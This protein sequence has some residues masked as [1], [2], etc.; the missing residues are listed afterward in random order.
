MIRVVTFNFGGN[1]FP[2]FID[3]TD[4]GYTGKDVLTKPGIYE[5][6]T[7]E[8]FTLP[9]AEM[10]G[11]IDGYATKLMGLIA[12]QDPSD[13]APREI[14][15][16]T[17]KVKQ[18]LAVPETAAKM[19][20]ERESPEMRE[21]LSGA[22]ETIHYYEAVTTETKVFLPESAFEYVEP[23]VAKKMRSTRHVH[24]L[25]NSDNQEIVQKTFSDMYGVVLPSIEDL[26]SDMDV[27]PNALD[28]LRVIA[29]CRKELTPGVF[30]YQGIYHTPYYRVDARLRGTLPSYLGFLNGYA[31]NDNLAIQ[32]YERHM[33]DNLYM[34]IIS[35]SAR[36]VSQI[37]TGIFL[38]TALG[39]KLKRLINCKNA[40]L[41]GQLVSD[42][43]VINDEGVTCEVT[44]TDVQ[45]AIS[46][47]INADELAKLVQSKVSVSVE[48]LTSMAVKQKDVNRVI[49]IENI[50]FVLDIAEDDKDMLTTT[51]QDNA[52]VTRAMFEYILQLCCKAY[53]VNWGHTGATRAIPRFVSK[54][55]IET[56]NEAMTAH[57]NSKVGKSAANPNVTSVLYSST[58]RPDDDDEG[59]DDDEDEIFAAFDYYIT[60]ST[61]QLMRD[62]QL[63]IGYLANKATG[64]ESAESS[65]VEYW[66]KV[67]GDNN[68]RYFLTSA[69]METGA[70]Q[71]LLE[72]FYKLMRWGDNKPALLVFDDMPEIR[73]VFDLNVGKEIPNTAIVDESQ[74]VM[75][76]GC[77]H[78]LAGVLIAKDIIGAD[79]AVVGFLLCKD[80]GIKK[81]SMASWVDVGE[82]VQRG[83]IDIAE[84]KGVSQ[85]ALQGENV[86]DITSLAETDYALFTSNR[87]IEMGLAN[88][89][90]PTQLSELALLMQPDVTKSTEYL[91]SK[92]S[93]V[94]ITIKDRQYQILNSYI[95]VVRA[96][97]DKEGALLGGAQATTVELSAVAAEAYQLYVNGLSEQ[98]PDVNAVRA[99]NAIASMNLDV[100]DDSGI[101]F[102][103]EA[104]EGKF[105]IISDVDME[106][107]LP[108]LDFTDA[109]MQKLNQRLKNRIV[110]LL[111]ELSDTYLLC[112]KDISQAELLVLDRK[113]EHRKYS[114]I[115]P[116]IAGLKQGKPIRINDTKS[117]VK[118]V[119]KFHRSLEGLV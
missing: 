25:K 112:R 101:E 58:Y 10:S 34:F 24:I 40:E 9:I 28:I 15:D 100:D 86:H 53:A 107:G 45:A 51:L 63:D 116:A 75:V 71:V 96:L 117:G 57:L 91:K 59:G 90:Q 29:P 102:S 94:V 35:D 21:F 50:P 64:A 23:D 52:I 113:I 108:T 39:Q 114:V 83:E 82:M 47:G 92:Q 80:Y 37:Y 4:T 104:L 97:Y 41:F 2:L 49:D 84:F 87:N 6:V 105:A 118:K 20:M 13:S 3:D 43:S 26:H 19:L 32:Q 33:Y 44:Y 110:L 81:Y 65:V 18:L 42:L 93:T 76:N 89:I 36:Y 99:Q 111:L 12:N 30:Q 54:N 72:A 14:Q 55:T 7:S 38:Q 119:L 17:A 77:K 46:T 67:N 56:I 115:A 5:E 109:N 69:F 31:R 79:N 85:V 98:A 8:S 106:S 27:S 61:R 16:Y 103:D 73:T 22:L 60:D 70:V 74:L 48:A 11:S 95:N 68:L 78:T 66:R 88:N 62:G 1:M